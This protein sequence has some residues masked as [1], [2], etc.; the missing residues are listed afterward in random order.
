M[1]GMQQSRT[2]F[3]GS[4]LCSAVCYQVIE[5][6]PLIGHCHCTMCQKFHGAAFSTF[7][8][9]KLENLY[10]VSG[11]DNLKSY[12]ADN[13]SIR[14]FCKTCGSS[15]VFCSVHNL[16]SGT[17]ELAISTLDQAGKL[18]PDAHIFMGS[19]VPWLSITD[20]LDKYQQ[21]RDKG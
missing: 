20:D 15:M 4:C 8:E 10:W 17:I 16:R 5:F 21:Y 9:V 14:K 18:K 1:K 3:S 7:A 6:E 2:K 12:Q 13:G 19:K 11:Y